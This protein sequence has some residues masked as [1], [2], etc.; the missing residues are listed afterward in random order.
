MFVKSQKKNSPKNRPGRPG[1]EK[2]LN[3]ILFLTSALG[4]SRWSTTRPGCFTPK[5]KGPLSTL[6]EAG[7]GPRA[8][9]DGC[10]NSRP[11]PRLGPQIVQPVASRYTDCA[12][13]ALIKCL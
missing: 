11:P 6:Q 2:S 12:L 13:P 4:E 5:E 3:F 7:W 8:R 1:G 9:L 10:G